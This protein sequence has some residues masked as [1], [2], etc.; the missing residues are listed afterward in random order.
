MDIFFWVILL[1]LLIEYG[2]DVTANILNLRALRL[3]PP[4]ALSGL[5]NAD[6]YRKSQEYTR[7][8]TRFGL[9]ASAFHLILIL[10]FWFAGG[11]NY[12]DRIIRGFELPLIVNGLLYIGALA[13]L[14]GLVMLPF[15]IY[16]TFV[17]EGRFGFNR[18]TPPTYIS[19]LLKGLFLSVILGTPLIA[20]FLL[21]FNSLGSTAWLYCFIAV[22]L[23]TIAVQYVSPVLIMPLFNKFTPLKNEELKGAIL[24][25][26]RSVG[27]RV[28]S[29][30]VMNG[31][32]RSNRANAFFTGFGVTKRIALFDTLTQQLTV[33]EIVAVLAHEIGHYKYKHVIIGMALSIIQTGLILYLLSIFI[34]STGLYRAFG[35]DAPSLYAGLVFMSLLF[36]PVEMVLSV[37]L[38]IISRRDEAQADN[39]AAM[40]IKNPEDMAQALKKLSVNNLT[41]LT[42]APF[43]VFLNY[44]HPPLL[45]RINN[46]GRSR[47]VRREETPAVRA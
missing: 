22:T 24:S 6:E 31:S 2:L 26:A 44:S 7:V 35:M 32:K 40:T 28:G 11:F 12:L 21:L 46:I 4:P 20:G 16:H 41:N 29:I 38:E 3:E 9:I 23:F 42:P 27:Y 33:P 18:T 15:N 47:A 25:Y 14:Y 36:T 30:F 10:A 1:S 37:I 17:I 13:L 39:F 19:D 34:Y 5:Y 8:S 45:E 43:F